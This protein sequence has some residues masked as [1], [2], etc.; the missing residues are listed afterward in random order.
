MPRKANISNTASLHRATGCVCDDAYKSVLTQCLK[1]C[2]RISF[3]TGV[4]LVTGFDFVFFTPVTKF[5][6]SLLVQ[7]DPNPAFS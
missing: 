4:F 7:G 5:L 3:V 2:F 1:I 6:T